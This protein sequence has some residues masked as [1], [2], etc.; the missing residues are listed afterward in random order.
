L[1][2]KTDALTAVAAGSWELGDLT[3]NR[4]GF[5]AMHL[6]SSTPFAGG[7]S[8]DR[9]QSTIGRHL[10][11]GETVPHRSG[12]R[13][14]NRP[15]NL[16]LWTR[17]QPP[18]IRIEDAVEWGRTI[19]ERYVNSGVVSPPTTFEKN[20]EHPWRCGDSDPGPTAS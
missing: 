19:I 17:P 4:V 11:D 10:I 20:F 3:V 18:G 6:A 5:G 13:D 2:M 8:N 15:E 12:V 1:V 14:D 16:E 9:D 7:V